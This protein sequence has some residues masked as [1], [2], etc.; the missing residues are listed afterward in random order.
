LQSFSFLFENELDGKKW[1]LY[2]ANY[3]NGTLYYQ[4]SYNHENKIDFI[5]VER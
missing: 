2:Q 3:S 1:I 5:T 4:I